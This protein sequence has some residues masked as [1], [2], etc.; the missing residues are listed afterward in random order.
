MPLK[1][2]RSLTTDIRYKIKMYA[3]GLA[4]AVGNEMLAME[5]ADTLTRARIR[6]VRP[7]EIDRDQLENVLEA[8]R[9]PRGLWGIYYAFVNFYESKIKYL[10][11][12]EEEQAIEHFTKLGANP[13]YLR[14]I[15]N[16]V[17][18]KGKR[19]AQP[20]EPTVEQK[21]SKT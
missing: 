11:L 10:G 2:K 8:L 21:P 5:Y 9:V 1:K 19:S 6:G 7:F 18:L 16:E 3:V 15:I 20:G 14:E 4:K 17:F 13:D 12:W